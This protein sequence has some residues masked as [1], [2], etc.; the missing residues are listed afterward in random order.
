MEWAEHGWTNDINF[1]LLLYYEVRKIKFVFTNCNPTISCS[2]EN[3]RKQNSG[4]KHT[5]DCT[6]EPIQRIDDKHNVLKLIPHLDRGLAGKHNL[7][8][9]IP[10][11]S[12][13]ACMY[14]LITNVIENYF[15]LREMWIFSLWWIREI[16]VTY[17]LLDKN[18]GKIKEDSY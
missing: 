8:R 15:H 1:T 16:C 6:L 14:Y 18:L 7:Q 17:S 11:I 5:L 12:E 9:Y 10:I 4:K 3:Y 13:L 2:T